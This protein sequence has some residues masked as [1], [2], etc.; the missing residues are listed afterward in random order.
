[1]EPVFMVLGQSA[2][3]AACLSI[4]RDQ[5]VQDLDY[6]SLR[7]QL[8]ADRQILDWPIAK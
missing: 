2:A 4:D 3:T 6:Q 1:M 8:L 7:Q 5:P